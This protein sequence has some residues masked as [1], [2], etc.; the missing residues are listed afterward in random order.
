MDFY[1][2]LNDNEKSK[3]LSRLVAHLMGDGCVTKKYFAYY[4]KNQTLINN[5]QNDV[6]TLF[7]NVHFTKG[8]TNSGTTFRMVQNKPI[9]EFFLTLL[10]DYKSFSLKMPKF[11]NNFNLQKEFLKALYDDEGSVG[12]RVF[13]KTGEIKRSITLSSNSLRLISE[14][15]EILNNSFG[16]S[17][18]KIGKYIKTKDSKIFTNYVLCITSKSNFEKF[19]D[20]IGF[21]HPEKTKKLDTMI[22]SYIR[23]NATK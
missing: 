4:N 8:I 10:E 16:I 3:V 22:N 15:K 14:I 2:I 1:D 12:L 5:F 21:S 19:R 13:K 7:E 17:S 11:V 9:R 20:N 18:N 6:S 23:H